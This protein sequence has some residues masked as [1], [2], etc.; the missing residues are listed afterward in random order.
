MTGL[1]EATLLRRSPQTP[2]ALSCGR[3]I[4]VPALPT[5]L[6]PRISFLIRTPLEGHCVALSRPTELS[7]LLDGY[8]EDR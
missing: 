6:D 1:L 2:E 5:P 3:T 7:D 8:L 4:F